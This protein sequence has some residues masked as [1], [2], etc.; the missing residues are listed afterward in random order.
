MSKLV[1]SN[2]SYSILKAAFAVHNAIGSGLLESAYEEAFCK[3]LSFRGIRYE[4]QRVL[5]IWF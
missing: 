4:R 2:L 1:H 3:E 5:A